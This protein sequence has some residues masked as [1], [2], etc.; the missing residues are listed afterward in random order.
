MQSKQVAFEDL[1]KR[2][3]QEL[4]RLSK[5]HVMIGS[6]ASKEDKHLASSAFNRV[7]PA[8]G[9]SRTKPYKSS[10]RPPLRVDGGSERNIKKPLHLDDRSMG[11]AAAGARVRV[12]WP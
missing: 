4:V 10:M 11:S 7:Q 9:T 12:A 5:R 2:D 6:V 8:V 3:Q 1:D